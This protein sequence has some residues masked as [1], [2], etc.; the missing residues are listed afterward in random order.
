[1]TPATGLRGCTRTLFV[2]S[3][4]AAILDPSPADAQVTDTML[5]TTLLARVTAQGPSPDTLTL[6]LRKQALYRIAVW[7]AATDVRVVDRDHPDR[8]DFAP[9]V[10]EGTEV[11]ATAI[12]LYPLE[13]GLHL[14]VVTLPAGSSS[15][16]VWIWEDTTAER[17]A[18]AKQQRRWSAGLSAAMGVTSGYTV[19][20]STAPGGSESV[21]AGVLVGSGSRLALLLGFGNDPRPNGEVSVNWAFAEPRVRL[22]SWKAAGREME[23]TAVLRWAQGN[24]TSIDKDPSL[25]A[26]GVLLTAHL[27]RRTGFRGWLLGGEALFGTIRN[28]DVAPQHNTRFRMSVSWLP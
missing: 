3:A 15:A 20:E 10:R 12:E 11:R 8:F 22:F 25:S 17:A 1:M 24:S 6:E 5:G 16:R 26:I 7:P 27:D 18:Q 23:F 9:R 19:A 21:E 4:L 14:L 28:L 13:S 2:A